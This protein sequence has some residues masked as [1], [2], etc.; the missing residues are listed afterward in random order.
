MLRKSTVIE[1]RVDAIIRN[2]RRQVANLDVVLY[3]NAAELLDL[4]SLVRFSDGSG[5]VS[6]LAVHCRGFSAEHDFFFDRTGL[7]AFVAAL[8]SM[9]RTL[10][11]KAELRTP[12]E[13]NRISFEVTA[14]GS[15]LVSGELHEY[16]EFPQRFA[17]SFRTDQHASRAS[18]S[19]F[20]PCSPCPRH[21]SVRA[22]RR[23][24]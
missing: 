10:G 16:S 6:K 5:F 21:R 24:G 12:Y 13:D 14:T 15:V 4:R 19:S 8:T 3:T 9:D 17:F 7:K 1:S 2:G 22:R 20:L 23:D 18:L 11:G